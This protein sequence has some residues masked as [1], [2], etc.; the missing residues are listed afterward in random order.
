MSDGGMVVCFLLGGVMSGLVVMA[1]TRDRWSEN[2][3]FRT[4]LRI[5]RDAPLSANDIAAAISK[6]AEDRCHCGTSAATAFSVILFV[7][8]SCIVTFCCLVE[9]VRHAKEMAAA[10]KPVAKED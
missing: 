6:M 7:I 9:Y 3:A 8:I 1:G 5:D 2:N 10:A 4:Q